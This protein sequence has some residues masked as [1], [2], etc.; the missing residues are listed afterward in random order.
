M[1]KEEKN[2]IRKLKKLAETDVE[3]GRYENAL[4]SISVCAEILYMHN[5]VYTDETLE[6]ILQ[7]ISKDLYKKRT[8]KKENFSTKKI[9]LFYD[10][11]GL[12]TRGLALIFVKALVELE[13]TVVY[14]TNEIAKEKQPRIHEVTVGAEMKW[15]YIPMNKGYMAWVSAL[16][17]VFE[18]YCPEVAFFY[19]QPNDVA[20]T[21]VFNQ[22]KGST[23]RYQID[24]TDH[25]FWLG[26]NAFDY[27]VALRDLGAKIAFNYRKIPQEKLVM[28]PY[29][30]TVDYNEPFA[31]FPF[32]TDGYRVLFSG[33]SL[34]K[35]LGDQDN[36]YY[37]IVDHI[38]HYHKDIIFLYAGYGDDSQLKILEKRYPNRVFHIAERKD[39]YQVMRHCVLYLNTYPMFGGLMMNYAAT[40]GKLPI[41]LKHNHD[42]DGLLFNQSKLGIEYDTMD[43]LLTDVDK[44]L[45]DSQYLQ[46]REARLKNSVITEQKFKI[47]LKRLIDDQNTSYKFGLDYVD[48]TEFRSEFDKRF[49]FSVAVVKA[50]NKKRN[51]KLV[52]CLPITYGK[53]MCIYGWKKIKGK[54]LKR[55]SSQ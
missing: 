2:V 32:P 31:G 29:Y 4:A 20:A 1:S 50:I 25:A 46:S 26:I 40:A 41:T 15:E 35:T 47:E 37:K 23:I 12:D 36:K 3:K 39:L 21:V 7:R 8:M 45:T 19:T 53:C 54:L 27:C 51:I 28:L 9:V 6:N 17:S 48:T 11:F 10:G 33:G 34:Y 38:L 52:K 16:E 18:T 14:V 5:Q 30:A 22:W 43:E 42:A 24:L 55:R 44:L 49:D 13:Y